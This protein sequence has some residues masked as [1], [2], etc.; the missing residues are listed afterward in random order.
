MILLDLQGEQGMDI[1]SSLKIISQRLSLEG[2]GLWQVT[3]EDIEA[4][5]RHEEVVRDILKRAKACE[6]EVLS[7]PGGLA[8]KSGSVIVT[9]HGCEEFSAEKRAILDR[10][11]LPWFQVL[12]EMEKK[13]RQEQSLQLLMEVAHTIVS[14]VQ[15]EEILEVIITTA[16]KSIEAA[17]TGFLFLYDDNQKKLLVKSAIGFRRE[18]YRYTRLD[19]GEGISGKV[20]QSAEPV[21]ITGSDDISRAMNNMSADNF[22]HYLDSAILGTFPKGVIS[23]PLR[24]KGEVI[25][26]LTIDN[27]THDKNFTADDLSLLEALANHIAVA[28]V[29]AELFQKEREYRE[30]LLL[31]HKALTSEHKNLQKTLDIHH[32]LTN[33]AAKGKGLDEIL[34]T[35]YQMLKLPV[36]I[37]T[38]LL[39]KVV[40]YPPERDIPLP[41]NFFKLRSVQYSIDT[42]KR[43][44]EDLKDGQ[45]LLV[46]PI[47]GAGEVLG[48]LCCWVDAGS[49]L[50]DLAPITIE[51]GATVLALEW[52]KHNAIL[53]IENKLKGH[54][55]EELLAGEI[56]AD[57]LRQ[58]RKLGFDED[59]NFCVMLVRSVN[60]ENEDKGGDRTALSIKNRQELL[61][62]TAEVLRHRNQNS[63][64]VVH[65]SY[66][67]C[68]VSVGKEEESVKAGARLREA[69]EELLIRDGQVVICIGRVYNGLGY[70][71]RSYND[72]RAC[73]DIID[74]FPFRERRLID[75]KELGIYRFLLKHSTEELESYL[76]D[77]LGSL[78]EY[79]RSRS[80]DLVETLICYAKYNWDLKTFAARL[81]IHYN[82]IYY[83][84]KRIKEILGVDIEDADNWASVQLACQIYEF[85][86]GPCEAIQVK[87]EE[88]EN[89][90][91]Y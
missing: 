12:G 65:S 60:R 49:E 16:L 86:Y 62:L 19:P 67:A 54:F 42:G 46:N 2:I 82:T 73:F 41:D 22:R 66:V 81:N 29:Q 23:V 5:Y 17:D 74:R 11:Y 15:S 6:G 83:R 48:F 7:F 37:Y 59:D 77:I 79:E 20:F 57:L 70:I 4:L 3:G 13:S 27:F 1:E 89:G 84:M 30:E 28:I 88:D 39:Q 21:L 87:G 53:E 50:D 32:R 90:N 45:M 75:Y 76:E 40:F 68:L 35:I 61:N 56:N 18:S 78:L 26:V 63:I 91:I 10:E 25:G 58:A 24:Y 47:V 85:L 34:Q 51:Y 9:L 64:S 14:S 33:L 80:G 31:T 44:I 36:A 72:A 8:L 55:F 69:A 71:N 43:Q 38:N 52:M